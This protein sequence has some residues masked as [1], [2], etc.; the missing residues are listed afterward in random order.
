MVGL[1]MIP[2]LATSA[3]TITRPHALR[4]FFAVATLPEF[5]LGT[6]V[7]VVGVVLAGVQPRE[8]LGLRLTA[9]SR[10]RTIGTIAVPILAGFMDAPA[11]FTREPAGPRVGQRLV[12]GV[13]ETLVPADGSDIPAKVL[14]GLDVGTEGAM[15][16]RQHLRVRPFA[17]PA[18]EFVLRGVSAAPGA[19][20]FDHQRTLPEFG[21]SSP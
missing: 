20:L 3:G 1:Q 6:A 15:R 7:Y 21:S 13:Q 11:H 2:P 17:W 14:A 8:E 4:P 16:L 5:L 12:D 19:V 18:A 9:F 10:P